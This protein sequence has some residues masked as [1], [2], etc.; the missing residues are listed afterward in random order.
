MFL[1]AVVK[2]GLPSRTRGDRG[3]E[4]TKV[5]TFMILACG[6]LRASFMW[7]TS[8][9]N[10]R[11]ERMWGEVGSVFARAWRAFFFRL[12]RLHQLDRKNPHHLWLLHLLF[13]DAI[14]QDCTDWQ[15]FWNCHPISGFG[16][17]RSPEVS[18][19]FI[20]LYNLILARTC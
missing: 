19:S 10:T 2:Y 5:S 9:H 17:D 15:Q 8:T 16:H 1:E 6:L 18:T 4:N 3:A 14:N 12:E 13:L 11:I 7:G 20:I